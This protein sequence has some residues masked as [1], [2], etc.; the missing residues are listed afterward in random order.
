[1]IV[2][3]TLDRR[4]RTVRDTLNMIYELSERGIGVRNLADPIKVDSSRPEDPT[5]RRVVV[6][7]LGPGVLVQCMLPWPISAPVAGLT[8]VVNP[9]Q[10]PAGVL[11]LAVSRTTSRWLIPLPGRTSRRCRGV[12]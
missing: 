9:V 8:G 1:M 7:A 3:H 4:G 2:V 11:M 12:R 5:A 6:A 10:L